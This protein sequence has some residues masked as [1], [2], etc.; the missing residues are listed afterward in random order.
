LLN[1]SCLRDNCRLFIQIA[2]N[3]LGPGTII[4]TAIEIFEIMNY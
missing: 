1:Y 2:A 3:C 4:K